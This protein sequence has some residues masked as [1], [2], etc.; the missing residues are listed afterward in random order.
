MFREA[1]TN[2]KEYTHIHRYAINKRYT[3]IVQTSI[4][5]SHNDPFLFF[6]HLSIFPL[7]KILQWISHACSL[8]VATRFVVNLSTSLFSHWLELNSSCPYYTSSKS[9]QHQT[10]GKEIG[11]CCLSIYT[12]APSRLSFSMCRPPQTWVQTLMHTH[13]HGPSWIIKVTT[14]FVVSK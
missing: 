13:E 10:K 9:M 12:Y 5:V 1:A 11:I 3:Y 7:R 2:L 14:F 6:S 4:M 8:F